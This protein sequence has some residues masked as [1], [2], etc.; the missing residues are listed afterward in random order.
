[1]NLLSEH[2]I[3]AQNFN[4]STLMKTGARIT[5]DDDQPFWEAY[6]SLYNDTDYNGS[7]CEGGDVCD[8]EEAMHF[9]A[10]FI[11]VLY[12]V[13]F[14]VG[15]L[16]NGV[17]LGVLAQ[18]RKCWS[19]TDTFILH[20]GVA[21]ILLLVTL[22]LWA[23]EA[24]QREGWTFGT[25]LC[26]ITGALF[27]INFYCGIFLLACISLDRYLSIVHA[28]Q[29]YSRRNPWVVQ[30]SCFSVWLFSLI[31]S[32]PD[33]IFLEDERD[34]RRE[35]TECIRNYLKFSSQ[36]VGEWRLAS[37]LLYH[38]VGFLVPSAILIFCY[39]CILRRLRCGNQGLQKQKAFRVIL[40]VVVVFFLCWTP[41]N[42]TLLVDTLHTSN[43][44]DSC[45]VRT[46]LDKAKTITSTIGYLHCSLNP[47]LYAFVGVKF[48]RQLLDILRSLGCKI[49]TSATLKSVVSSRRSSLWSESA[50][51]SNSIA[52]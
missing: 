1:M 7:C 30:A 38:I 47:I 34:G 37:R 19:V 15:I 2:N 52:I 51:T 6:D 43:N 8:Q 42:I 48:R 16:G 35:K 32:I 45:D 18:S 29:M 33:W 31:L 44:T 12:S 41:Y 46:T 26:K 5:V 20:L 9:E 10:V 14:V 13:A 3:M 11:P 49:K 23:A 4:W 36:S 39:S 25:P 28:T 27:T 17:L 22:P 24:A 40:S 21:D 50:D